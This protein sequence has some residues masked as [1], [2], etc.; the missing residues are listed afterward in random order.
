MVELLDVIAGVVDGALSNRSLYGGMLVSLV[1]YLVWSRARRMFI[2]SV[3]KGCL[4][5]VKYRPR[6]GYLRVG[7]RVG[8]LHRLVWLTI[9]WRRRV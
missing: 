7:V 1:V 3:E 6:N 9:C 2:A 8:G 4:F 5:V